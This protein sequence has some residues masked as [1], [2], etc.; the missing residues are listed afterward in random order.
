LVPGWR[1]GWIVIYDRNSVLARGQ[2]ISGLQSVTQRLFGPNTLIAGAL[3]AIFKSTPPTFLTETIGM[4]LKN[5]ELVCAK[6]KKVPGLQPIMPQVDSE[7]DD[8]DK[9]IMRI[10]TELICQLLSMNV[11]VICI[12]KCNFIAR[13]LFGK[14]ILGRMNTEQT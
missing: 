14:G 2:V 12:E 3:S 9:K 1:L 11:Y 8:P 10:Y 6:L 4:V 7:S 5:A 13:M